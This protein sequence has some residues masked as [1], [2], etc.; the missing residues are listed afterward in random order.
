[1]YMLV[2]MRSQPIQEILFQYLSFKT[3]S[4]MSWKIVTSVKSKQIYFQ[5]CGNPETANILT[6]HTKF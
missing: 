5:I 6:L 4:A 3:L 2:E 1:M